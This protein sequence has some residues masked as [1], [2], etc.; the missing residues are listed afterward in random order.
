[1]KP[2]ERIALLEEAVVLEKAGSLWTQ[3][4]AA[5][6][7]GESPRTLRSSDCP[8]SHVEGQGPKGKPRLV[9]V[10]ADVRQWMQK[11]LRRAG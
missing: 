3:A 6:V 5:A 9:Y 7:A 2:G 11:R 1:M 4:H 10:P 8:K